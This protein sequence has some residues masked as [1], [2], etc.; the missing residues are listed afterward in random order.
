VQSLT[1][2]K[3]TI[4]VEGGADARY[5]STGHLIY[6]R[7]G[8]LMAVPFDVER[9]TATGGSVGLVSGVMQAANIINSLSDSGGGQFSLSAS[10]TLVYVPGGIFP[11]PERS[12][13][14]V[15]RTGAVEPLAAEAKV[16]A[17]PK[18]SPDG[19]R[20]AV[21]TTGSDQNIW[22]YD[23]LRGTLTRLVMEYLDGQTLAERL[24]RAKDRALP[25]DEALTI[26]IQTC[27]A[28]AAAPRQ[29][30]VHR[31]LKPANVFLTRSGG[32]SGPPH[33]KLLDFGIAKALHPA[34]A[35]P[36]EAGHDVPGVTAST[37][38]TLTVEGALL[39][40]L[41]YMAPEQLEGREADARS[42][43]F[44]FGAFVYEMLTGRRAFRGESQSAV[45]A[46]VLDSE[47]SP[48]TAHQPLASPVLDH[49]VRT[50]L[51]KSP[52]NRW[53]STAG[54][55]R[56]LQW[57]AVTKD[58]AP[59]GPERRPT[60]RRLAMSAGLMLVA[61]TLI[62]ATVFEY[63]HRIEPMRRTYDVAADGRFLMLKPVRG[64]SATDQQRL[65]KSMW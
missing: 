16:Y 50:C 7:A 55:K 8:T 31:D 15:N 43:L 2:G 49:L 32:P 9:L 6:V 30:I 46:A 51:A 42:D 29:G 44:A 59:R 19:K 56:Q 47:P 25:M 26:A 65:C 10:G 4:L 5:V 1:T 17:A 3:R 52:D 33:V 20:V 34:G 41:Q 18:L 27:D 22:I 54:V 13:V 39:G 61:G 64:Q 60:M 63:P 23:I 36:A 11:D 21:F 38:P 53:Q 24:A 48:I 58:V 35:G 37:T 40:T 12:L 45:I 28:L 14:W 62:G 57:I